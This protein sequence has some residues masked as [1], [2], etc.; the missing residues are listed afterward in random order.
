MFW[1][2]K[3]TKSYQNNRAWSDDYLASIGSK[4]NVIYTGKLSGKWGFW[5][6]RY[7]LDFKAY[8]WSCLSLSCTLSTHVGIDLI[9]FI[10]FILL[11][12]LYNSEHGTT[13]SE[14]YR[15][16]LKHRLH[17]SCLLVNRVCENATKILFGRNTSESWSIILSA[18]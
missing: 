6:R 1:S 11:Y 10:L 9:L 2:W 5:T 7:S 18:L 13:C 14:M 16:S 17:N 3:C 8:H 4:C 12:V 15:T